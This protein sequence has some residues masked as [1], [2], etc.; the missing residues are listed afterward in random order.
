M[1]SAQLNWPSASM[2]QVRGSV[3]T[4]FGGVPRVCLGPSMACT[5]ACG[6]TR[7]STV[8]PGAVVAKLVQQVTHREAFRG[9]LGGEA[10]L[11]GGRHRADQHV[12]Q[13]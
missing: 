8:R 5:A 10:P 4:T 2:I 11:V 7:T 6:G 3:S 9:P 13:P 12:G 1:A